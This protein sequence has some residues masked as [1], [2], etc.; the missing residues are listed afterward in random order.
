MKKL[1]IIKFWTALHDSNS[2][3][4]VIASF[5]N[6]IGYESERTLE[7]YSQT[8]SGFREGLTSAEISKSTGWVQKRIDQ[9]RTWWEEEFSNANQTEEEKGQKPPQETNITSTKEEPSK[10]SFCQSSPEGIDVLQLRRWG[11]PKNQAAG[12]LG[13]WIINHTHGNHEIC[14]LLGKLKTDLAER[15]IPY[16]QAVSAFT[17]GRKAIE[18]ENQ[19]IHRDIELGRQFR[20]WESTTNSQTF[21]KVVQELDKP[22]P[23]KAE[24]IKKHLD[25]LGDSL[26]NLQ[27]QLEI[28]LANQEYFSKFDIE[29]TD[30]IQAGCT[31]SWEVSHDLWEYL[32][33]RMEYDR[34]ENSIIVNYRKDLIGEGIEEFYRTAADLSVLLELRKPEP[35]YRKV[36]LNND[37][38]VLEVEIGE[39]WYNLGSGDQVLLDKI[40]A[41]H[42]QL[43]DNFRHHIKMN[44][45]I[46]LRKQMLQA[47]K[48][49]RGSVKEALQKQTYL[50]G[51][52][53]KCL[54]LINRNP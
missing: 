41:S 23:V 34:C 22:D 51:F 27:N 29:K 46:K 10:G 21:I 48:D 12:L 19:K 30:F 20:P 54:E 8:D 6:K 3:K 2:V 4:A 49:V 52:C 5:A 39:R 42:L 44:E 45:L 9:L 25:E 17:L 18:F 33:L 32:H 50:K 28:A 16:Q 37:R 53:L 38:W 26:Q 7:R 11:V 14:A 36:K 47:L 35:E 24:K 40:Q 15:E 13:G 43:I 1:Q 31:H